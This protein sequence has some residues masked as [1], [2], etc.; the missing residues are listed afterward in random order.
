MIDQRE[1]LADFNALPESEKQKIREN[2][3]KKRLKIASNIAVFLKNISPQNLSIA[4]C[5][6]SNISQHLK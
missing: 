1:L 2:D 3:A 6:S 5:L 4:H